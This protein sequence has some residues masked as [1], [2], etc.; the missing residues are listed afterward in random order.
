MISLEDAYASCREKWSAAPESPPSYDGSSLNLYLS[1]M[2]DRLFNQC[3]H[4]KNGEYSFFT[5][6]K[7]LFRVV[8]DVGVRDDVY[9]L[10]GSDPSSHMYLF[11]PHPVFFSKL[12]TTIEDRGFFKTHPHLTLFNQGV[13]DGSGTLAYYEE[14]QS[15][16]NRWNEQ[17]SKH[18]PVVR[19][20]SLASLHAEPEI[21]FLKIDTEGYELDVLRGAEGLLSKTKLIQFEYGGT[22][23]HRGIQLQ[24]VIRYLQSHGFVFFYYF[25]EGGFFCMDSQTVLEHQQYSNILASKFSL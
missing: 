8:V 6:M 12:Q 7:G 17:P 20:D 13:S 19:L 16:V 4:L 18:L 10:E 24:D 5:K 9:Y 25:L 3:D 11:E 1:L 22:Y 23:P 14:A 2:K 15:F 21:S